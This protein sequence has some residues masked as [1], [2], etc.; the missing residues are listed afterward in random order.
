MSITVLLIAAV[1]AALV[2]VTAAYTESRL[3]TVIAGTIAI[4]VGL[5]TGNPA[6]AVLD[7]ALS[8]GA[9]YFAFKSDI[10]PEKA[11]VKA[12]VQ[13]PPTPP[14]AP[15]RPSTQDS[16]NGFWPTVTVAICVLAAGY[17]LTSKP[18][19]SNSPPAS[20]QPLQQIP[21]QESKSPESFAKSVYNLNDQRLIEQ[22]KRFNKKLYTSTKD[23]Y[24]S[25][26]YAHL[27]SDD[28]LRRSLHDAEQLLKSKVNKRPTTSIS[29]NTNLTH[30][31]N[32]AQKYTPCV[33]KD[34]MSDA[35]YRACGVKPPQND[36][37]GNIRQ[38]RNF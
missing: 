23:N 36:P 38:G 18:K 13:A 8:A 29:T 7:A 27:P 34:V 37:N 6:Y 21:P 11:Q 33:Y 15:P 4:G 22:S 2:L 25:I 12:P 3:A 9:L 35:D 16:Q 26:G 14:P 5:A 20:P 30:P 24:F 1:P 31:K 17:N 10:F 19:Q 28:A 32:R